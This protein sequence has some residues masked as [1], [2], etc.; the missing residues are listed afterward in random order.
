M[1]LTRYLGT[2][3][4]KIRDND[5]EGAD[6]AIHKFQHR[7]GVLRFGGKPAADAPTNISIGS[8]RRPMTR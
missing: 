4:E 7:A 3:T 8:D 1:G 6:E 5:E 2:A